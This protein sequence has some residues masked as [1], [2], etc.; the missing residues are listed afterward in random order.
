M[1]NFK[2]YAIRVS[3]LLGWATSILQA[4]INAL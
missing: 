3:H 4:I 1:E 2:K